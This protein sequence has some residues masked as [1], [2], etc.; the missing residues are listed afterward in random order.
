GKAQLMAHRVTD[1]HRQ[2]QGEVRDV[3]KRMRRVDGQWCENGKDAG[4]K[5]GGEEV[6]VR[7][8]QLGHPGDR[9]SM[10][11]ERGRHPVREEMGAALEQATG[12]LVDRS[13]LLTGGHAIGRGLWKSGMRLLLQAVN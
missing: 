7:L 2:V 13:Q 8:I 3:G 6:A 12:S 1:H 11:L 5:L 9:D 10:V 4:A